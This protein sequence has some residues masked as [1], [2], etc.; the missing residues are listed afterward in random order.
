MNKAKKMYLCGLIKNEKLRAQSGDPLVDPPHQE[1]GDE[2][3]NDFGDGEGGPYQP[4]AGHGL[5][6]QPGK[7]PCHRQNKDQLPA[8]G[9]NQ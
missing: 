2:N 3:G 7:E 8:Q 1:T 4:G 9:Q 6:D 5:A